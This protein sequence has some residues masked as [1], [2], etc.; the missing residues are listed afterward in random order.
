MSAIVRQFCKLLKTYFPDTQFIITTHDR[1]WAEQMKS[2]GLVTGKTSLTFHGWSIDT[3]PV[4]EANEEVWDDIAAELAKG[5]HRGRRERTP[6]PSRIRVQALADELS[7]TIPF[8]ADGNYELGD[9]LPNV[10]SCLKTLY[11]KASAAAQFWGNL[12]LRDTIVARRAALSEAAAAQNVEQWAVNKAVHYNEW[13]NFDKKDFEPVVTAFNELMDCF[14]C[15]DCHSWLHIT[16][17][18]QPETLRCLCGAISFNLKPKPK[19]MTTT[20]KVS[21]ESPGVTEAGSEPMHRA[22]PGPADLRAVHARRFPAC[23]GLRGPAGLGRKIGPGV[24]IDIAPRIPFDWSK[25]SSVRFAGATI[26]YGRDRHRSGAEDQCCE[27][28]LPILGS[29]TFKSPRNSDAGLTPVTNR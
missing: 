24:K 12:G 2:A 6:S 22:A 17:R 20:T 16:P 23:N 10:L 29:P 21:V 8:R 3:G 27:A 11:G 9:L 7:A 19:T 25:G 5:Q 1:L 13:A 18:A 28:R 26:G 15:P 4:V 14:N